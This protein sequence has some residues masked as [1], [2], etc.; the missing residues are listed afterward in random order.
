LDYAIIRISEAKEGMKDQKK[1]RKQR[2]GEFNGI[3]SV[4]ENKR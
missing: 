1:L 3:L 4:D 2:N